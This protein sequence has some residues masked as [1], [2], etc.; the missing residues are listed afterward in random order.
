MRINAYVARSTGISRRA[1]DKAI[2]EGR[3]RVNGQ[4]ADIGRAISTADT[5]TL[6]GQPLTPAP[7]TITIMLNKPVG[8]VSSR[9]GQGSRTIYDLL[10]AK[11]HQ[12]KPVGRL[13]K[14]SSGLLLLTN[15]GGLANHLTH[16]RYGKTKTY[17]VE[18]DKPLL[19]GDKTHL[20]RGVELTDGMSRLEIKKI[21]GAHLL[22][23]MK[24]GRNRQ[25]RRTFAALGYTVN[26][27]HRTRFGDYYLPK[28][29]SA[30]RH[31]P[32]SI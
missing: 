11:Y 32:I 12:L 20:G 10:P 9:Q 30:G 8:Y 18:L 15:D 5:V 26:K 3:V 7:K 4:R 21:D 2:M 13:D 25:I 1:A 6:D 19:P 22:V 31:L 24:E 17:E 29:L 23:A 28:S 14:D 27:L 16:P